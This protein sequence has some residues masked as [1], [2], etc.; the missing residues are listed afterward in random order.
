MGA[1]SASVPAGR[2]DAGRRHRRAAGS[3]PRA[4]AGSGARAGFGG[5]AGR[6][7][8]AAACSSGSSARTVRCGAPSVARSPRPRWSPRRRRTSRRCNDRVRHRC[9]S[10]PGSSGGVGVD[11][12]LRAQGF[13]RHTFLC[14]QSGSGKTYALGVLLEQLLLNTEL[15]MVVLDP[16]ADFVRLG[17]ARPEAPADAADRLAKTDVRVLGADATGAEPLRMRFATMPRRPRPRCSGSTRSPTAG[18]TTTSCT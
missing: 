11:A 4:A 16:N 6:A 5:R 13:G 9:P 10:A 14:G 1:R 17:Q 8:G 12:R 15:R 3:G 7:P 2:T 18:S